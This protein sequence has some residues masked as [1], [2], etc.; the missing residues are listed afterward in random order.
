MANPLNFLL[1]KVKRVIGPAGQ[2]GQAASGELKLSRV[3]ANNSGEGDNMNSEEQPLSM[4][5]VWVA[6]PNAMKLQ[7]SRMILPTGERREFKSIEETL[8]SPLAQSLFE[9]SGVESVA[10][11]SITV[12]VHMEEDSDWEAIM[13]LIPGVIK[14][15]VESGIMAVEGLDPNPPAKKQFSFGFKQTDASSRPREEQMKIIRTLLDE[16]VNPAVAAH[17]GYFELLDVKDDTVYVQLGGGCVGCGMVDVTLRQGVEQ[18]MREVLPE[19]VALVDST[20]H[21]QGTNPYYQPGK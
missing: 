3:P 17:G 10:L 8:D 9:I 1:Q 7:I 21:A 12:T 4:A 6:D 20:D 19:M 18:R 15:H 14:E 16:E 13:N 5:H 11:D 2:D